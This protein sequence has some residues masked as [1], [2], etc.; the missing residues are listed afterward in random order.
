[1]HTMSHNV[2]HVTYTQ[3]HTCDI[4]TVKY[5]IR[6]IG[7]VQIHTETVSRVQ[8]HQ[9]TFVSSSYVSSLT[10]DRHW[11]NDGASAS[12]SYVSSPTTDRH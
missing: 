1:M 6:S 5:T 3:C 4:H 11:A 8:R 2:A 7:S 10:T 12:S 9:M